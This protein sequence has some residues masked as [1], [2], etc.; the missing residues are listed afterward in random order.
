MAIEQDKLGLEVYKII[1]A[2]EYG[3][4]LTMY[5][6]EGEATTTPLKAKWIYIKPVNFM[7]QLPDPSA[8]ERPE[9]YFWKQQGEHDVI[10][11]QLIERLRNACNQFGVGLTVNDFAQENTPKQF[12][13]LIQRHNEERAIEESYNLNEGMTGTAKRSFYMLENVRLVAVHSCAINEE[14][15][16]SRTRNIKELYLETKQGERFKYPTNYLNGAKAMAQHLNQGGE[17]SDYVGT[18]IKESGREIVSINKLV[19]ECKLNE[20]WPIYEKARRYVAEVKSDMKTAQGPR[21]YK[22]VTSKINA[23]PRIAQ[24]VIE[25]RCSSLS[26]LTG[27]NES[28][29]L[30]E[31]YQYFARRDLHEDKLNED[32][33]TRIIKEHTIETSG[34]AARKG[35]RGITRGD[36]KLIKQMKNVNNTIHDQKSRIRVYSKELAECVDDTLISMA[37]T[38][39]SL[40]EDITPHDAQFVAGVLKSVKLNEFKNKR[41]Q[42]EPVLQEL[43]DWFDDLTRDLL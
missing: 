6:T 22:K 33:Y 7:I 11:E 17:W 36:V 16:G 28:T 14:T 29:E 1:A 3:Y 21:G 41:P 26:A 20:C 12:Q 27:L 25:S 15:H 10:I 19:T 2:R 23:I 35:A 43:M 32:L 24:D 40:K 42:Q 18:V 39:M 8:K 5:D 38:E 31:A 30:M 13:K 4:N 9:I 37:L 34:K